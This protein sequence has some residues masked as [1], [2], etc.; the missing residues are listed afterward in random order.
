MAKRKN[1]EALSAQELYELAKR[2][3]QEELE[4]ER[5]EVKAQVEALRAQRRELIAQNKKAVGAVDKEILT[6]K[7][8]IGSSVR[9]SRS[10]GNISQA[11]LD[12]LSQSGKATTKEIRSSLEQSGV[13]TSNLG[14]CL[15]YL[16]RNG[17]IAAPERATYTL[18]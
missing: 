12:V 6:L 11:V 15:A 7:R 5:E 16:K 10:S 8:S 9:G 17:R 2:R 3:E 13:D 1:I 4:K 14:Q 18:A